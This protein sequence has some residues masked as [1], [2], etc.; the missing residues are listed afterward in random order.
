ML[1]LPSDVIT[2]LNAGRFSLRYLLRVDLPTGAEGIWNGTHDVEFDGVTYIKAGANL[3]LDPIS[4]SS[5]L[6]A[7]QLRVTLSGVLSAVNSLLDGVAWHQRA[8]TVYMAF[9]TEAGTILHAMPTFSGFLD[10]LTIKDNVGGIST[11]EVV[12]ESNNREL[13]RSY[14][15]T[16]SDADQRS[17]DSDDGF[18]K[19]T[20]AANTDVQIAW[21]RKGPQYPVRPK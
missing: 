10:T 15:R 17:V 19:Y 12:I 21:G 13:S 20:T 9:L 16:R 3:Q 11:I 4:G 5:D 8:A 2:L 14:G 18:F 7:D 1:T 6:D